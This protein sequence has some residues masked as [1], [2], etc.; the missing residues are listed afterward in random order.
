MRTTPGTPGEEHRQ[1]AISVDLVSEY[2]DTLQRLQRASFELTEEEAR[3]LHE[4]LD[5]L[6]YQEMSGD[7][8]REATARIAS[9]LR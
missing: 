6:W 8:C 5:Q 1:S 7:D 9:V 3:H 4:R 2:V